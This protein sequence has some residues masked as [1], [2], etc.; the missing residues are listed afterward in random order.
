MNAAVGP[1]LAAQATLAVHLL[2]CMGLASC[3]SSAERDKVHKGFGFQHG[4]MSPFTLR[5]G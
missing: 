4:H 5:G 1:P 2:N 3:S